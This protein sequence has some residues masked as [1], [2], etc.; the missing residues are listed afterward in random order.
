MAQ[1]SYFQGDQRYVPQGGA[2]RPSD[3]ILGRLSDWIAEWRR[4]LRRVRTEA[5]IKRKLGHCDEHLLRDMGLVRT[6]DRLEPADPN[7]NPWR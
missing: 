3:G 5:E 7:R 4:V 1:T 6:G 2:R